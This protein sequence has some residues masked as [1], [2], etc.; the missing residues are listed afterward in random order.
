M[1]SQLLQAGG[2]SNCTWPRFTGR[3]WPTGYKFADESVISRLEYHSPAGAAAAFPLAQ[4]PPVHGQRT[5]IEK[6]HCQSPAYS[7]PASTIPC[8]R[9]ITAPGRNK[10]S[11]PL[12]G[13][14]TLSIGKIRLP[15]GI[16]CCVACIP[17][18][19]GTHTPSIN[20]LD[21]SGSIGHPSAIPAGKASNWFQITFHPALS[22]AV[23][24]CLSKLNQMRKYKM[25]PPGKPHITS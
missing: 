9:H 2:S 12:S 23:C 20:D 7:S 16:I 3:I 22:F 11:Y 8:S 10:P 6:R 24:C 18:V 19:F 21:C 13:F 5:C 17:N 15:S 14:L 4:A 25:H 1:P